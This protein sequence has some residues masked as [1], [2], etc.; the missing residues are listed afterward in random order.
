MVAL[1]GLYVL[2][3]ATYRWAGFTFHVPWR[4]WHF[5]S[6]EILRSDLARSLW[7]LH[8]QPPVL[9]ALAGGLLKLSGVTGIAVSILGTG[10]LYLEGL[11][12]VLATA[13]LGSWIS[14]SGR[15]GLAAGASLLLLPGFAVLTHQFFYTLITQALLLGFLLVFRRSLR[16]ASESALWGCAGMLVLVAWTRT[17]FGPPWALAT[18]VLTLACQRLAH[19]GSS[20]A[21]SWRP[22]VF[23][24][25][26]LSTWPAKNYLVFGCFTGTTWDGFNL[27]HSYPNP[28]E[29]RDFFEFFE[30]H[31]DLSPR[32]REWVEEFSK[33]RADLNHPAVLDPE[34]YPGK[35]NW[36]HLAMLASREALLAYAWRVRMEDPLKAFWTV[37][38]SFCCW[39]RPATINPWDGSDSVLLQL[40]APESPGG[41]WFHRWTRLYRA[42]LFHDLGPW[43]DRLANGLGVRGSFTAG[44]WC[45]LFGLV[46]MPVLLLSVELR[47][48]RRRRE[49]SAHDL[50][51][52]M[53]L[54]MV[55]WV[56]V[57]P[58]LT[59]GL[60]SNRMRLM[61]H[62]E[63]LFL[64]CYLVRGGR[65]DARLGTEGRA[66]SGPLEAELL[67][68][69]D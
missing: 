66:L 61:I 19:R 44:T 46:L 33:H 31:K 41:I 36:N 58:C 39:S 18:W 6:P 25:V 59:D 15:A 40:Y 43:I 24:L 21:R 5:L 1:V 3:L 17:L 4:H 65:G 67:P 47:L 20:L 64:V 45:P 7:L 10:F 53:A 60:E 37:V 38:Y 57:I 48:V 8:S 42:V 12:C 23:L 29:C 35:R 32:Q 28:P 69:G 52:L 30:G 50:V 14:G 56:I 9:N 49:W 22:T 34:G 63:L 11:F 68:V 55:L 26:A 51:A 27:Q 62:P 16:D 2:A 54:S 13:R